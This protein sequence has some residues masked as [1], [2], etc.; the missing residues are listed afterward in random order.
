MA[1]QMKKGSDEENML[2]RESDDI[3]DDD[4]LRDDIEG[5]DDSQ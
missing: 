1:D 5:E 4:Y 3:F 2:S